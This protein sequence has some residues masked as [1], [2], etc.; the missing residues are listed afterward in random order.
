M[1]SN[2]RGVH[3]EYYDNISQ[4]KGRAVFF[5]LIPSTSALVTLFVRINRSILFPL[6]VQYGVIKYMDLKG[7]YED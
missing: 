5:T 1:F 7:E 2:I 4:L 6:S 3:R